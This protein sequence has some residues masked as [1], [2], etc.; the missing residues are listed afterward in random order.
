MK[1]FCKCASLSQRGSFFR[2]LV[3][4]CRL[5]NTFST[6][7]WWESWFLRGKHKECEGLMKE[8]MWGILSSHSLWPLRRDED[9]QK[10]WALWEQRCSGSV[11]ITPRSSSAEVSSVLLYQGKDSLKVI[12]FWGCPE[13]IHVF[14][15]FLLTRVCSD[16]TKGNV[17]K[18]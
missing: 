11:R 2:T 18:L 17:F 13:A 16:R 7:Q 1:F 4:S 8:E 6:C 9:A 12:K 15:T 10:V 5:C 14:S 3:F